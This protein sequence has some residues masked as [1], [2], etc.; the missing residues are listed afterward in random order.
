VQLLRRYS[1]AKK[2]QSQTVIREKLQKTY[3]YKKCASSILMKLTPDVNF[4][5]VLKKSADPKREKKTDNLIVFFVLLGSV[6]IKAALKTFLKS[7]PGVNFINIVL[8]HF[9][10]ESAFFQNVDEIDGRCKKK[11]ETE[12]IPK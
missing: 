7:T 5:N 3:L 11:S 4:I 8:A 2:L 1:F 10:Y 6:R 9:L 12:T